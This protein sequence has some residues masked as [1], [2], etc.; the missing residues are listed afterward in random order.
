MKL[1]YDL[2][3]LLFFLAAYKIYDIYVAT[4][5]AIAASAA[6]VAFYWL[7]HRRFE[8]LHLISL[9]AI[10]VLGGL[11]LAIHDK[12]FVMWKPTVAMWATAAVFLGTRLFGG[13]SLLERMLGHQVNVPRKFWNSM[14]AVWISLFL[15]AGAANIPF[16]L[17]YSRAEAALLDA[18]PATTRAQIDKLDCSDGFTAQARPLCEQAKERETAWVVFKVV[19]V[20]G[21]PIVLLTVLLA[22]LYWYVRRHPNALIETNEVPQRE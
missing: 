22:S 17:A 13:K 19:A 2:F 15:L 3:P 20:I 1:L 9:G 21:V 14:D 10:A 4:A 12:S 11:T 5:V 6:Q 7:K 18:A 8:K 16:A